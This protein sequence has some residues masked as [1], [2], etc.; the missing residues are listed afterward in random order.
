MAV[1]SLYLSGLGA[2]RDSPVACL[3]LQLDTPIVSETKWKSKFHGILFDFSRTTAR[4]S[5]SVSYSVVLPA[6]M[7]FLAD[8]I[9]NFMEVITLIL[10]VMLVSPNP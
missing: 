4:I 3:F 8:A 6:E 5:N 7:D 2:L 10:G 9:I 1:S